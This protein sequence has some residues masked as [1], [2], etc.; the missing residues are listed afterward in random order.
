MFL[1][2]TKAKCQVSSTGKR[3]NFN[4]HVLL[5][6]ASRSEYFVSL[7]FFF[8]VSVVGSVD[9]DDEWGKIWKETVVV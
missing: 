5:L 1:L 9:G 2:K 8:A 6:F 3:H 7:L 4:T